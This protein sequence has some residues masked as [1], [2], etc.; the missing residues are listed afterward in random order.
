[1][2]EYDWSAQYV[3]LHNLLADKLEIVVVKKKKR[4]S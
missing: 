2:S 1:M 4:K 3:V